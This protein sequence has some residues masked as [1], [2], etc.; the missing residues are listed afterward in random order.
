[1]L[2]A[3]K[4]QNTQLSLLQFNVHLAF[5]LLGAEIPVPTRFNAGEYFL[6]E[7]MY[8]HEEGRAGWVG[9]GELGWVFIPQVA[10]MLQR[11]EKTK[12]S[13]S[14]LNR[15]R[16]LCRWWVM[17]SGVDAKMEQEPWDAFVTGLCSNQKLFP[18]LCCD[19]IG[20]LR[21]WHWV[22]ASQM[23]TDICPA[24]GGQ[25]AL[26]CAHTTLEIGTL[27]VLAAPSAFWGLPGHRAVSS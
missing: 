16:G 24:S 13:T 6:S 19:A 10:L 15:L 25:Q 14:S 17:L 9:T 22:T 23:V 20:W 1:M 18:F 26:C 11:L 4:L 3:S 8:L 5:S 2:R 12:S 7:S 21:T 27:R